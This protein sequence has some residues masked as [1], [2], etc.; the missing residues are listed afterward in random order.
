MAN[1]LSFTCK[2]IDSSKAYWN[3]CNN[4]FLF[5]EGDDPT[6]ST[7]CCKLCGHKEW[8]IWE[9]NI[10]EVEY[11]KMMLQDPDRTIGYHNISRI[12]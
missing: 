6:T 12:E 7:G 9:T 4:H 1:M 10:S 3:L 5:K 2:H 11:F 8:E